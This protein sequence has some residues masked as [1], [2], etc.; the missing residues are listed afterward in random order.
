MWGNPRHLKKSRTRLLS[1][2]LIWK[3]LNYQVDRS[4]IYESWLRA[5]LNNEFPPQTFHLYHQT[6][7]QFV[8][9]E[10]TTTLM[11]VTGISNQWSATSSWK[12]AGWCRSRTSGLTSCN[13]EELEA[14]ADKV[15]FTEWLTVFWLQTWWVGVS[16]SSFWNWGLGWGKPSRGCSSPATQVWIPY[17]RIIEHKHFEYGTQPGWL[18]P[19]WIP[20]WLES[21][22]WTPTTQSMKEQRYVCQVPRSSKMI[23]P[24]FC[25]RWQTINTTMHVVIERALERVM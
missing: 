4:N 24:F 2:R 8:D 10:I 7:S 12:Y 16:Q 19:H 25:G 13:R 23:D 3:T 18:S 15:V 1:K 20:G 14:S 11:T 17:T 5:T 6:S 22:G 21:M 9:S